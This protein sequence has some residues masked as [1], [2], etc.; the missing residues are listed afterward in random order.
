ME[1]APGI[2]VDASWPMRDEAGERVLPG[3]LDEY[4]LRVEPYSMTYKSPQQKLAELF[5]ILDHVGR[6]WPM[7]QASGATL[8]AREILKE[9]ARL[10]DQP[11]LLRFITFATPADRLGGDENTIRQSPNTTREHIRRNIPT[12]GTAESR[13]SIMQQVLLGGGQTNGAQRASLSRDPA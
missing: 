9:I 5:S 4:E 8:D 7:F 13:S 6:M 10:Q 2:Q 3:K 1:A 12:G 11:E